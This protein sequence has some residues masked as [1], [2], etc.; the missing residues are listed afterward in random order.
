MGQSPPREAG[1]SEQPVR[2]QFA[3]ALTE[4]VR[5][6]HRMKQSDIAA[7]VN[8]TVAPLGVDVSVLVVDYEQRGLHALP[9]PEKPPREPLPIDGSVAGRA[10]ARIAIQQ[11]VANQ[12][13][14]WVP[15][16]DGPERLGVLEVSLPDR[17]SADDPDV[18]EACL[19]LA[20][21]VGH[22]LSSKTLHGDGIELVRRTEPMSS[23]AELLRAVIPPTTFAS[24]ELVVSAALE[25][26][27]E[28]GG[29][30][31]DYAVDGTSAYVALFDAIGHGNPASLTCMVAL[32]AMRAARRDGLGLYGIARMADEAITAQWAD[33]RFVTAFLA[34]LSLETGR[35]RYINAGHPPPVLLRSGHAVRQL[36]RGRR[37]PLGL[38]D[39][40]ITVAEELLEP[41]DRLLLFTDGITEARSGDGEIFGLDRLVELTERHLASGLPTPEVLRRVVQAVL[42]HQ[43]GE[44][45]DDATVMLVEWSRTDADRTAG[46]AGWNPL[47]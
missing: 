43:R 39:P 16:L 12:E 9:E 3:L 46:D 11:A 45:Q 42:A 25:P 26:S 18:R 29:D 14:L 5:R 7:M 15:V 47:T 31:F 27:Y 20:G 40:A 10:F 37:T 30:G 34:D 8:H 2:V 33:S 32:S 28:V 36:D 35:L 6:A 19:A 41:G 4:L 1:I 23:A 22:L 21:L 13:R 24:D 17:M 38:D 44:L